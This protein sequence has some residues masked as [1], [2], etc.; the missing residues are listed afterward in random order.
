MFLCYKSAEILA[1]KRCINVLLIANTFF[2]NFKIF[3]FSSKLCISL[4]LWLFYI[5][6]HFLK[7]DHFIKGRLCNIKCKSNSADSVQIR[8]VKNVKKSAKRA[9]YQ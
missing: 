5:F 6:A 3:D 2:I 7:F 8:K 4:L 9:F 1:S